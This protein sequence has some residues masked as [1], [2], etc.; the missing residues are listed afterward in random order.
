MAGRAI[1]PAAIIWLMV[2][3]SWGFETS[4]QTAPPPR[5]YVFERLCPEAN[6]NERDRYRVCDKLFREALQGTPDAVIF[7]RARLVDLI[8]KTARIQIVLFISTT[9]R[10]GHHSSW[11]LWPLSYRSSMFNG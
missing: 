5:T 9:S 6:P 2:F 7:L 10:C 8:T 4:A 3:G 11:R 1:T